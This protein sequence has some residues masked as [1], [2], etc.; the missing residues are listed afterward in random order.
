MVSFARVFRRAGCLAVVLLSAAP[1]QGRPPRR[2][3]APADAAATATVT[4]DR[5]ACQTAFMDG[6]QHLEAG[7][8]R[9][10]RR[11]FGACADTVCGRSIERECAA[12]RAQ[13]DADI[14]SL[15]PVLLDR[16]GHPIVDV[17]VAI[18]GEPLTTRLGGR[19]FTVDPGLHEVSFDTGAEV[20]AV[21]VLAGQGQRNQ[22]VSVSIGRG[23]GKQAS[24]AVLPADSDT[25]ADADA[26]A[27]DAPLAPTD[28]AGRSARA[29]RAKVSLAETGSSSS[30]PLYFLG[31]LG[32]AGLLGYGTLVTWARDDNHRLLDCAPD[33]PPAS[34]D[35]IRKLYLIADVSLG[36][37]VAALAATTWI[38]VATRPRRKELA[39]S[40]DMRLTPS[41][42]FAS[43]G[44]RF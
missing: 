27:G 20:V 40:L 14:P 21:K 32:V 29:G 43:V 35:H 18:D 11:Y 37:G 17:Q 44:G 4:E 9:E 22:L 41:G 30:L 25:E 10:A 36:V 23:V 6:R 2:A 8:L 24:L 33:C 15:V 42:A 13:L 7:R 1:V 19:A 38:Y 28:R 31:G 5:H 12:R 39:Y 16:A 3:V 26:D 34:I